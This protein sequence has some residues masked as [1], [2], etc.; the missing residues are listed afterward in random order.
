MQ[1]SDTVEQPVFMSNPAG[2]PNSFEPYPIGE[3]VV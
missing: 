1:K 2:Y 3:T